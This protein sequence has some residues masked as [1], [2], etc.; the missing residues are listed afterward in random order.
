MGGFVIKS[1]YLYHL[2]RSAFTISERPKR[3]IIKIATEISG[4]MFDLRRKGMKHVVNAE[5]CKRS[6]S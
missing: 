5:T 6:S 3:D 4:M 1:G 2:R